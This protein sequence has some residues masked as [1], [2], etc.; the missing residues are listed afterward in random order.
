MLKK[1]TNKQIPVLSDKLKACSSK[2]KIHFPGWR[3]L[4]GAGSS[5][6]NVFFLLRAEV[7]QVWPKG[8]P[9]PPLVGSQRNSKAQLMLKPR[10]GCHTLKN[11]LITF[12]GPQNLAAKSPQLSRRLTGHLPVILCII[13]TGCSILTMKEAG[14]EEM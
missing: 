2:T 11:P 6:K 3:L 13:S 5:L 1:Q 10:E 8:A 7:L 4:G 9:L 12:D 14:Q